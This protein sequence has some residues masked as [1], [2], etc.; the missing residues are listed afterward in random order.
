MT[1]EMKL[2]STTKEKSVMNLLHNILVQCCHKRVLH[3]SRECCECSTRKKQQIQYSNIQ[4]QENEI[5]NFTPR[6]NE[7]KQ[8]LIL[9]EQTRKKRKKC[10]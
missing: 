3:T 10:K 4:E 7:H 8:A 1:R 6:G 5:I 9:D 2:E